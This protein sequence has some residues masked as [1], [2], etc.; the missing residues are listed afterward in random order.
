MPLRRG[1]VIMPGQFHFI[2]YKVV[3]ENGVE[4]ALVG[5]LSDVGQPDKW[6]WFRA[7]VLPSYE[8][9]WVNLDKKRGAING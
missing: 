2:V 4:L 9:A 6:R 1:S 8:L 3:E 7:S 5:T